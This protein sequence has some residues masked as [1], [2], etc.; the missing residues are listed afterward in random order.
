[1]RKADREEKLELVKRIRERLMK[2]SKEVAE[3]VSRFS[4]K[5]LAFIYLND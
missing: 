2:G 4:D 5:D 3:W 1:M